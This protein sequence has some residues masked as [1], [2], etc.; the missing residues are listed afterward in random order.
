MRGDATTKRV[1]VCLAAIGLTGWLAA[2]DSGYGGD[3][4][5]VQPGDGRLT[6]SWTL[7]G[8]P[9]TSAACQ[10]ARV[11]SMNVLI[12]SDLYPEQDLQ[13][14]NVTCALDRFS[15]I[16][17]PVG[18][19]RVFVDGMQDM[20]NGTQCRRYAGQASTTATRQFPNTPLAIPL[21]A[22]GDCR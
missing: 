13:F 12:A 11:T 9:L 19:V 16:M 10:Q 21:R 14:L 17:T 22:V 1:K 18:S 6:I 8:V 5:H 4:V 3:V 2:C 7:D 15:S 20:T